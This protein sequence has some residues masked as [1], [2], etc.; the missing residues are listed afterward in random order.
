MKKLMWFFPLLAA[1]ATTAN[2]TKSGDQVKIGKPKQVEVLVPQCEDLGK[3][4]VKSDRPK[5][6]HIIELR[7]QA[8]ALG[9]NVVVSKLE[10]TSSPKG[11]MEWR[12]DSN[13]DYLMQGRSYRCPPEVYRQVLP[14]QDF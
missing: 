9:A 6:E 11:P 3:I 5:P 10:R 7:N 8:A 1:C 14:S 2:L 13:V 4:E 12:G